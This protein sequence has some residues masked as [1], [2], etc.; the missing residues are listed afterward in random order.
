[1]ISAPSRLR[2][3]RKRF[4]LSVD[5][6][7]EYNQDSTLVIKRWLNRVEEDASGLTFQQWTPD[8]DTSRPPVA[9]LIN[10]NELRPAGFKLRE[11]FRVY[12]KC[13]L[14]HLVNRREVSDRDG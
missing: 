8:V 5:D 11:V 9:M 13:F 12:F 14:Q 4:V 1:M 10:S 3:I 2:L 6:D 7:T